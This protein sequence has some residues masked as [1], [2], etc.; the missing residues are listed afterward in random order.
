TE[1]ECEA[2]VMD[3][4]NFFQ[5]DVDEF[6]AHKSTPELPSI[7]DDQVLLVSDDSEEKY[8][9]GDE[10]EAQ[11]AMSSK[12]AASK[13]QKKHLDKEEVRKALEELTEEMT[14]RASAPQK[15]NE[16]ALLL[17]RIRKLQESIIQAAPLTFAD[18]KA[19]SR[20]LELSI[21]DHLECQWYL[22]LFKGPEPLAPPKPEPKL[23]AKAKPRIRTLKPIEDDDIDDFVEYDSSEGPGLRELLEKSQDSLQQNQPPTLEAD[24]SFATPQDTSVSPKVGAIVYKGQF[25]LGWRNLLDILQTHTPASK[26]IT[27]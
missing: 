4:S 21:H 20:G 2:Y 26:L 8:N 18:V 9:S 27:D 13:D 7:S 17:Q 15:M 24:N 1:P 12:V 10:S 14:T 25:G 19:M 22:D 23:Q 11:L 16:V 5:M 6:N 3:T